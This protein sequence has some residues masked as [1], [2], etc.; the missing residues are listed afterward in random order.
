M[1]PLQMNR[2]NFIKHTTIAGVSIALPSTWMC[3]A[4]NSP[5]HAR[6][7][8]TRILGKTGVRVPLLTIG[9]GSRFMRI[10]SDDKKLEI[11]EYGLDHGLFYWDT[12]AIYKQA[13][14]S[15]YGEELLGEILKNR[16]KEVFLASKVSDRDPELAKQTIENSLSRLHTDY[17]D[18]YQVHSIESVE[19]AKQIGARG[20]ILEVLHKYR[21]EGVIRH[22]GFTGHRSGEG[23]KYAAESYDFET[24]IIAMNHWTQW[25]ENPEKQAIPAAARNGLGIIAMKVIRPMD[26]IENLEPEKLIRYALSLEHISTAV[27]SAGSLDILKKN[28]EIIKNFEPMQE[29]DM[30]QMRVALAP[31]YQHRNLEWMKPGYVDGHQT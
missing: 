21:D 11:L 5:F 19:D 1:K 3:T 20:G 7:L 16:R 17:L 31:Y 13:N 26:T 12:A 22:L 8:P 9:T 18:L 4:R 6:G 10:A 30:V 14:T 2:R 23:M 28:L 25:D 15:N 24:M 27:I 29:E